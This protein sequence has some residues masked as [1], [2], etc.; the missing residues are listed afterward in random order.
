MIDVAMRI[1]LSLLKQVAVSSDL[2]AAET[3][4]A[5]I[6]RNSRYNAEV[7]GRKTGERSRKERS[8][9]CVGEGE[10][11]LREPEDCAAESERVRN[12][13]NAWRVFEALLTQISAAEECRR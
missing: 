5:Y 12:V 3:R 9:D 10:E 7:I 4:V 1:P 2:R 13:V 11:T 8:S 6:S